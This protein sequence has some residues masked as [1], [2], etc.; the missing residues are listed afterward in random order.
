MSPLAR[1]LMRLLVAL[2]EDP[3]RDRV[4]SRFLA[5]VELAVPGA[6]PR[7][8]PDAPGSSAGLPRLRLALGGEPSRLAAD[9]LADLRAATE[10]LGMVLRGIDRREALAVAAE[11]TG[12]L[13]AL[14]RLSQRVTRSLAVE[15]V[16]SATLEEILGPIAPDLGLVFLREG[17]RLVLAGACPPEVKTERD[18]I[19]HRV[20]LCLCGLAARDGEPVYSDDVHHDP[21]CLLDECKQAGVRSFAALPLR[22]GDQDMGV[23]GLAWKTPRHFAATAAFYETVASHVAVGLQNARLHGELRRRA[24]GLEGAVAERTEELEALVRA[25]TG[26]EARMAELKAVIHRLRRQL[27]AAGLEPADDDPLGPWLAHPG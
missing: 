24:E 14:N 25:M 3:H 7:L 8:V 1:D 2:A 16:V 26:R 9:D 22:A 18:G 12:Q 5:G 13:E 19:E 20:G 17:S 10:L 4:V 11:R 6:A 21:R 15:E 23:L 27:T